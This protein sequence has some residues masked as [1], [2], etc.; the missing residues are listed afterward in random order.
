[1]LVSGVQQSDSHTHIYISSYKCIIGYYKMLNIVPVLYSKSFLLIY[2]YQFVS[3]NPILQIYLPTSS[4]L[5]TV[6]FLCWRAEVINCDEV[7][8]N[9]LVLSWILL[10]MLHKRNICLTQD[11]KTVLHYLMGEV[12][13]WGLWYIKSYFLHTAF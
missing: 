6:S 12:L 5:V 4:P 8:F 3:F 2:V 11:H 9:Q 7:Q 10:L 1:M 13:R